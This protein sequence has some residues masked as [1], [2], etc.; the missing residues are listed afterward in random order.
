[1]GAKKS[2]GKPV[3]GGKGAKKAVVKTKVNAGSVD[4]FLTR[5]EAAR[6]VDCR[7]LD[8]IFRRA[9]GEPG[10]MWGASIVGYG[11]YTYTY[12][13]GRTGDWMLGGFSPRAQNLTLYL[14]DG[15]AEHG[16]L[17]SR[18]GPHSTGKACLYIKRLADVDAGVLEEL[19]RRS[20]KAVRQRQGLS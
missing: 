7:A 6:R 5:Q 16:P 1:V 8:A 10:R 3:K 15:F 19:V 14:M 12:P 11:S 17:L 18:L 4:G 9:T 13:S 2:V 20:I